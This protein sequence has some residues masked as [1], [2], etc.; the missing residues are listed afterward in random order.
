M[1]FLRK[2]RDKNESRVSPLEIPKSPQMIPAKIVQR[3]IPQYYTNDGTH[4][5]I[6]GGRERSNNHMSKMREYLELTSSAIHYP[7]YGSPTPPSGQRSV[8]NHSNEHQLL[9]RKSSFTN[10]ASQKPQMDSGPTVPYIWSDS[11]PADDSKDMDPS[12][13]TYVTGILLDSL[14]S[15]N[16]RHEENC[17]ETKVYY[18]LED[19]Q[20]L[21]SDQERCGGFEDESLKNANSRIGAK[22]S[23]HLMKTRNSRHSSSNRGRLPKVTEVPRRYHHQ[24][25][26]RH[27]ATLDSTVSADFLG[28][29]TS[30]NKQVRTK[31]TSKRSVSPTH[32][33]ILPPEGTEKSTACC[34]KPLEARHVGQIEIE[35]DHEC[36]GQHRENSASIDLQ[37]EYAISASIPSVDDVLYNLYRNSFSVEEL[38]E[39]EKNNEINIWELDNKAGTSHLGSQVANECAK[40]VAPDTS[41]SRKFC[42]LSYQ[43]QILLTG[44]QDELYDRLS[45]SP[46][47]DKEILCESKDMLLP[48][49]FLP[50]AQHISNS[51]HHSGASEA[52]L[53]LIPGT[54]Y[55]STD[56]PITWRHSPLPTAGFASQN[57]YMRDATTGFL[58]HT[59]NCDGSNGTADEDYGPPGFWRQNRLY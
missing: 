25:S 55:A 36:F 38:Q 15:G 9:T 46:G 57:H 5:N 7:C 16:G 26:P 22:G 8:I 59:H 14:N 53:H 39:I 20:R 45:D 28:D 52:R 35:T 48:D 23:Q 4:A 43:S 58:E 42:N 49:G 11:E 56:Q 37:T 13:L 47:Q 34:T 44:V 3:E 17:D 12:L 51:N 21:C 27:N 19:L 33:Q 41:P 31:N 1:R 50:L 6:K 40:R 29:Y 24:K 2:H 32:R 18:D 10:I 54:S 30:H